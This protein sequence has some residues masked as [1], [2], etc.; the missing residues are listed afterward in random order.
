MLGKGK[1]FVGALLVS[2]IHRVGGPSIQFA[3]IKTIFSKCK[4]PY[5][6]RKKIVCPRAE[7]KGKGK[8]LGLTTA[9][10]KRQS[11]SPHQLPI[12][13][14]GVTLVGPMIIMRVA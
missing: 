13:W 2:A 11:A 4:E 14:V 7:G 3:F 12:S 8:V 10:T 5:P 6:R 9:K 1:A